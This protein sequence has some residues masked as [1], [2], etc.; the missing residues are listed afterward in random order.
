MFQNKKYTFYAAALCL[1]G[2][3]F[4]FLCAAL[5]GGRMPVI[6]AAVTAAGGGWTGARLELPMTVGS[7]LAAILALWVCRGL[8]RGGVCQW[9]ILC[10]ALGALGCVG[11]V[12]ANGLDVYGGAASGCYPLFFVS[13]AALRCACAGVRLTLAALCVQWSVRFRGRLLALVFMGAPL[14]AAIGAAP[15]ASLVRTTLSGDYRPFYLAAAIALALLALAARFLLRDRPEDA[16]LYPDGDGRAPSAVPEAEAPPM[17]LSETLKDRRTWLALIALGALTFA[18]AGCLGF[19]E[20]RLVVRGGGGPTLL[21]RAAPWLALGAILAIPSG[22]VFGW[23][24]DRVGALWT[25]CLLG[26]AELGSVCLLWSFPKE[27]A[28]PD[29]MALCLATALLTGGTAPVLFCLIGQLFGR[30]QLLSACRVLFPGL[31]L[32]FALT[33]PI[34]ALL[35]GGARARLYAAL[36]AAACLGILVCL[37]LLVMRPKKPEPNEKE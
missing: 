35:G 20:P 15:F 25:A 6:R 34:G 4:T 9:L 28:L 29:G 30:S 1:T 21:D 26:L 12:C 22:Y 32:T 13:L 10:A 33:G 7:F 27:V 23:L 37:A 8:Q 18:S 2:L 17:S 24:C 36:F 14:F 11:L 5:D 16:G 31:L 3:L 19:L